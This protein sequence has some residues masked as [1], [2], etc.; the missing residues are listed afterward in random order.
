M[1]DELASAIH[2]IQVLSINLIQLIPGGSWLAKAQRD[3]ESGDWGRQEGSGKYFQLSVGWI[4]M[5]RLTQKEKDA[6]EGQLTITLTLRKFPSSQQRYPKCTELWFLPSLRLQRPCSQTMLS[7][8][9]V[10]RVSACGR[11]GGDDFKNVAEKISLKLYQR[12]SV[13]PMSLHT[14]HPTVPACTHTHTHI[15]I[16]ITTLATIT[17]SGQSFVS[18]DS[19]CPFKV[20]LAGHVTENSHATWEGHFRQYYCSCPVCPWGTL[21][22]GY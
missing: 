2:S 15:H 7:T 13:L 22:M 3:W 8:D 14:P 9:H 18:W 10:F 4:W 16:I 17:R 21:S 5:D 19:C 12:Q 1:Y 20:V 11:R 6:L